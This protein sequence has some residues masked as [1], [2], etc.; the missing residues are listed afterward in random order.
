MQNLQV[1]EYA[2]IFHSRQNLKP[3]T[4][5]QCRRTK[6]AVNNDKRGKLH[7]HTRNH[8][9]FSSKISSTQLYLNFFPYYP[10][11]IMVI[12]TASVLAKNY[13]TQSWFGGAFENRYIYSYECELMFERIVLPPLFRLS[14]ALFPVW[15]KVKINRWQP[16]V[17][18][19]WWYDN[20][21]CTP[22][23]CR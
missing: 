19:T 4:V 7:Y 12:C 18:K 17:N 10:V 16:L 20:R 14:S 3:G 6:T 11:L 1:Y 21:V 22:L 9:W 5:L 8:V 2:C 13:M 15:I 23:C